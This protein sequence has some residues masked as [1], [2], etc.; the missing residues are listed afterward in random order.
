MLHLELDS[1]ALGQG[2]ESLGVDGGLVNE[3]VVASVLGANK[4]EALGRIEKFDAAGDLETAGIDNSIDIDG[5]LSL[6]VRN[7]TQ[8]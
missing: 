4:A 6:Y 2:A 5:H 1:L 3:H 8:F 7:Y